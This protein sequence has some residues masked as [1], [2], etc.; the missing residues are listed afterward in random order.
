LNGLR[1][2]EFGGGAQKFASAYCAVDLIEKVLH[3]RTL[4]D[5]ATA[6]VVCLG[7]V[8]SALP[9]ILEFSWR[10]QNERSCD[11]GLG[12]ATSLQLFAT[13]LGA[14]DL[15]GWRRK[16]KNAAALVAA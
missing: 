7:A 2:F 8:C 9:G 12:G 5:A 11:L 1:S 3:Y 4:R 13:G 16:R 15:F 6:L 10:R 14:L